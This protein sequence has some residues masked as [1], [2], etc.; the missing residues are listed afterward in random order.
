VILAVTPETLDMLREE[1]EEMLSEVT[2]QRTVLAW[3]DVTMLRRRLLRAK[4]IE[5]AK[6]GKAELAELADRVREIVVGARG[7]VRD[8]DWDDFVAALVTG[9]PTARRVVRGVVT[10][11]ESLWWLGGD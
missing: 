11:L 8:A 1:A 7:A 3:E 5:V 4:P 9:R 6:L 2:E 10:R